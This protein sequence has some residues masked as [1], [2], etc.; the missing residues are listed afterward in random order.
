TKLTEK[1]ERLEKELENI[2]Q[3][4]P[5]PAAHAQSEPKRKQPRPPKNGYKIPYERIRTVLGEAKRDALKDVH[6]Q[7]AA[8]LGALKDASAPAH[9]TI[10]DSKPAAASDNTLVVAFKYD[11]H[12]SLFLD[13]R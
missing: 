13:N 10:Q 4:K 6:K 5:T 1:I 11:I 2:K 3:N 8:F 12:C 9:A 7:W